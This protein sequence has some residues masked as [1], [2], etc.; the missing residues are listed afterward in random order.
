MKI[1]VLNGSP[2]GDTSVTMQYVHFIQKKF[3]QHELKIFNISQ[4]IQLI[5]KDEKTYLEIIDEVEQ[6][7]GVLWAFPLYFYLV[8]AHYKRFIELIFERGTEGVFQGKYTAA[9]STSIHLCDHI[10]HDYINAICDD[11]NMKYT[12]AFSAF[13]YDLL[14]EKKR[15]NLTLFAEHFFWSIE[16]NIPTT[17]NFHNIPFTRF[18]YVPGDVEIK[19]DIGEKKVLVLTDS[20]DSQTNLGKMIERFSQSFST[21]IELINLNDVDIKGGCQGC[22]RCSYDN[23]CA[24]GNEDGYIEFFNN[25]VRPADIL[26]IAG[27]IKDH[28]LSSRWKMFFDRSYFNNHVPVMANKQIG[29]IISGPL[30]QQSTLKQFLEIYVQIHKS[31]VVDFI[32]DEYE[33]SAEIDKLLQSLAERLLQFAREDYMK[34]ANFFNI[35]GTKILRDYIYGR[36][37]FPFQADHRFYKKHGLYDFPHKEYKSRITN[38]ILMLLTK[39][40]SIRNDIYSRRLK[41]EI[42][43]PLQKVLNAQ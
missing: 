32:T 25:K 3:P 5:E 2:K 33:S 26:V 22:L 34:P 43:K 39:I 1:V 15:T 17:K 14:E 29:F 21:E 37:R 19:M 9:L 38:S 20:T 13:M 23:N 42:I 16:N 11:L 35:G 24:Y 6:A 41:I 28:Y 36:G 31:S 8:H 27:T 18:N 4:R 10:A 7:D 30:R 12:G 40:P